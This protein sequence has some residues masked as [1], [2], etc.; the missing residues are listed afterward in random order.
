MKKIIAL[1]LIPI[2]IVSAQTQVLF[3]V[4]GALQP[5]S[6]AIRAKLSDTTSNVRAA[7]SVS[8]PP[9]APF[10]YS[11]IATATANTNNIAAL[12]VTGLQPNTTYYYHIEING[13]PDNRPEAIATFKTPAHGA[14]SFTFI[15]GSC[16]REPNTNT[17]DDFLGYNPLFY[18]NLGDLHYAD[19]NSTNV[20]VHRNAYE[21]RVFTRPKQVALFRNLPFAYVWDDHDYCGNSEDGPNAVGAL[22]AA[23]AYRE[24]I[25]HYEF[26]PGRSGSD[27]NAIYQ[28]FTIG[29]VRFILSDL[30]S[31]R[32]RGGS[33]SAMGDAQKQWFKNELLQAKN[34]N[35][36]ICWVGSYSWY[37]TLD[38]NWRLN[39]VERQELSE[40]MRDNGIENMFIINGDAHMFAI[41]NGSNGDFTAAQDLPYLY[42]LMQA[43]PI[44]NN[45]S[46]KGGTYSE[47]TFYQLFVKIA[48]YG[49]IRIVDNGADSICVT[50][51]GYKKD[52]TSGN[53]SQLVSYSF[54]RNI[55]LPLTDARPKLL[56]NK[57]LVQIQPNPSKGIFMLYP[58]VNDI[59]EIKVWN[60]EG[61]TVTAT[62]IDTSGPV[63]LDLSYLENGV[64]VL[65]AETSVYKNQSKLIIQK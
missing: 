50:M 30:R 47:G 14:Y 23:R 33:S 28:A 7:V 63:E 26:P 8:N 27:T 39:P 44:E 35:Q 29:R 40:F 18:L 36:L 12:Y 15:A 25:P 31:Q 17:Y 37:G 57:P 53:T 43:G 22:S 61:K 65:S 13:V 34:N 32:K 55:G 49:V 38:D 46:Y 56:S 10:V 42:P 4:T 20:N 48:Q 62:R 5:N 41:D 45:G 11:N 59:I 2:G 3:T 16:N 9:A 6:V 51:E 21:D 1:L 60:A 54:C 64:Y 19:P 52:L 24:Y 58:S